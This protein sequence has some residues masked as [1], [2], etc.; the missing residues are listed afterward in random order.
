MYLGLSYVASRDLPTVGVAKRTVYLYCLHV[1]K[2]R[3]VMKMKEQVPVPLPFQVLCL[4]FLAS[5]IIDAHNEKRE[6]IATNNCS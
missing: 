4:R 2:A 5:S 6:Q 3:H 1:I